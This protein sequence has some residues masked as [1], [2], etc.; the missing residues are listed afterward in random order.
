MAAT[1]EHGLPLFETAAVD[2]GAGQPTS[3]PR[4][5][6]V[7][8]PACGYHAGIIAGTVAT[9]GGRHDRVLMRADA[10]TGGLDR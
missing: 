3:A 1:W 10:Q 8:C 2:A 7:I 9:H 6:E 4:L 5:V